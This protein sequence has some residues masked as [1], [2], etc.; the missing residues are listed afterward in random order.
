M[1]VV[2]YVSVVGF[3]FS[4]FVHMPR[5]LYPRELGPRPWELGPRVWEFDPKAWELCPRAQDFGLRAREF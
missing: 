4:K 1:E 3:Y 2:P 5:E